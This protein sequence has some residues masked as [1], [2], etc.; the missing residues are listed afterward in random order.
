ML[1]VLPLK[2]VRHKKTGALAREET[3]KARSGP[4][5]WEQER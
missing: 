2:P 1:L 5:K 3:G 4:N